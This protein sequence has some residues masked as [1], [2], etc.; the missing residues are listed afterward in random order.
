MK[1]KKTTAM[2]AIMAMVAKRKQ[3]TALLSHGDNDVSGKVDV[4]AEIDF[5]KEEE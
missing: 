1:K 3:R 2:M 5:F 4:Y